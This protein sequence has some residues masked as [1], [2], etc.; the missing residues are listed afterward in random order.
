[1]VQVQPCFVVNHSCS[2]EAGCSLLTDST[3]T[4]S[5]YIE[6]VIST[7]NRNSFSHKNPTQFKGIVMTKITVRLLL[8]SKSRFW[9]SNIMHLSL[10]NIAETSSLGNSF[11][12]TQLQ[13][14][15]LYLLPI[16]LLLY[17]NSQQTNTSAKKPLLKEHF[18]TMPQGFSNPV[19]VM[20]IVPWCLRGTTCCENAPGQTEVTAEVHGLVLHIYLAD[21]LVCQ[22]CH[23]FW[24]SVYYSLWKC[25]CLSS[26]PMCWSR[27][28]SHQRSHNS[29]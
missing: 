16:L 21:M 14:A 23:D 2:P 15:L 29:H 25:V 20:W 10:G 13:T 28:Q 22:S 3:F 24:K 4:H 1:M 19:D 11:W 17:K 26:G 6:G 8:L 5:L 18:E 12:G 27:F 7:R 9:G